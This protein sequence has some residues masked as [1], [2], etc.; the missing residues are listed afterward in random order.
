MSEVMTEPARAGGEAIRKLTHIAIGCCAI[1][2]RWLTPYQAAAV[3]AVAILFNWFVLPRVGGKT[4]ART[5]RG[6]D[7]GLVIYP[8]VVLALILVFHD[9]LAIAG[10]AWVILAFG[11]GAATL[12]GRAIESRPLPWNPDK[13]LLGFLGFIEVGIPAAYAISLWLSDAPTVLPRFLIVTIAVVIAAVVESLPLG[14]DDNISIPVVAS[15]TLLVL[16]N[17]PA[18]PSLDLG[19]STLMWLGMNTVLAVAGY[20]VRTVDFSGFLGGW[21]LGAIIVL[22]GGWQL[23]LVLLAFFVIATTL[24]KLGV[25][26]KEELGV[27]QEKGGRRGFGHAFANVGVAAICALLAAL[28][29]SHDLLFWLAAVASLATAAADTTGS[30]VGQ[31]IGRTA[32]LPLT[33]RR[34]RPGTEGAISVE[35]TIAGVLSGMLVSSVG[36]AGLVARSEGLEAFS[37]RSYAWMFLAILTASAVAGSYLESIAGS[38]NRKL[39]ILPNGVLNFLNTLV[40][41]VLFAALARGFGLLG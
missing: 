30:E 35:G 28:W 39:A 25:K 3:A 14:I 19:R 10:T 33:F 21:L 9:Q 34:V 7:F 6:T 27:A 23:Y 22:F 40:G 18:F 12:V 29:P 24:T 41:A 26:R 11:D 15:A 8:V 16:T 37:I 17:M 4:I 2:L 5:S 38:W 31:W 13:T 1:L 32:F 20:A 36:L